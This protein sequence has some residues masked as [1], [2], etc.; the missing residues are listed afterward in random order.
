M[1]QRLSGEDES[2]MKIVG[3]QS[4]SPLPSGRA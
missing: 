3:K 4:L 2:T 1:D